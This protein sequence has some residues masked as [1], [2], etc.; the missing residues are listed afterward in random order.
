[1]CALD[2]A[3]SINSVINLAHVDLFYVMLACFCI[4]IVLHFLSGH[5]KKLPSNSLLLYIPLIG[6]LGLITFL[7]VVVIVVC[8]PLPLVAHIKYGLCSDLKIYCD[9]GDE[10]TGTRLD[11]TLT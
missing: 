8:M 9:R 5:V 11:D 6:H 4:A 2:V 3:F 7:N 10:L 1:M